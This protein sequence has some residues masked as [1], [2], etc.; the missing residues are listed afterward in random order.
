MQLAVYKRYLLS[1]L[2]VI[3]AFN[4]VDRL[5]LGLL[6]QDIKADLE[7]SDTQLGLLSGIAFAFFYSI[8]GLPIA[9]WADRGDRVKIIAI[10]TALWSVAMSL[11]GVAGNF[12]QL[13]LIRVGV[14]VG[15]AGCVP[16]AHSLIAHYFTRAE[17]PRAVGIY[18]L[19]GSV[20]MII[21]YFLAGWINEAYGWRV[22]FMLLGLPGLLLSALAWFTLREPRRM[23]P[24]RHADD[25]VDLASEESIAPVAGTAAAPSMLEV[26]ATL[27][28]SVTFRH[29]LIGFSIMYFFG[30]GI[31]QWQP[32]FFIRSFGMET[33]ELGTW[34]AV[35]WGGAGLLGTYCGG[36][37]ASRHAANN[38]SLQLRMMAA[39]YCG[40]GLISACIYLSP[41]QYRAFALMAVTAFGITTTTGPLFATVQTLVPQRMR[42]TSIAIIY[43]FANLIG[44]GLG[45]LATGALSDALR[46]AYGEDSLRF[47]LFAL[48]PGYL[49]CGWHL[50]RASRTVR[51]DL[52]AAQGSVDIVVQE[53]DA[54]VNVGQRL[55]GVGA[56]H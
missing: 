6:L 13:L 5:A 53:S 33:G 14:A 30:Y 10:T 36:A 29:L 49:W 16:P 51:H 4:Y 18:M 38:E 50:W 37:L 27:W 44:M 41:D 3:L 2:L 21:G 12:V 26:C 34:L 52:R 35:V 9:R 23:Q 31:G 46:P 17:R 19:G 54:T 39:V 32:A 24:G 7:L 55:R 40:V 43:L 8:M 15:E 25:E 28:S 42:A 20:S 22:T 56:S 47:A 1:M 11:F 48:S 45:P